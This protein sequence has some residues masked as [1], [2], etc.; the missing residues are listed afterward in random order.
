MELVPLN[1]L[2]DIEPEDVKAEPLSE[3]DIAFISRMAPP[4]AE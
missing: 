3:R 2:E 4:A 1:E